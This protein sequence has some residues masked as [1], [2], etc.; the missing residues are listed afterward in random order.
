MCDLR[1]KHYDWVV[2]ILFFDIK[3]QTIAIE[4]PNFP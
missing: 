1:H 2:K 3:I 4:N